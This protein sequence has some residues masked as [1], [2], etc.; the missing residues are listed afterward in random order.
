MH[1]PPH[2]RSHVHLECNCTGTIISACASKLKRTREEASVASATAEQLAASA[3]ENEEL[4][5]DNATKEQRIG[6][7]SSSLKE[8][9]E[10]SQKLQ[11]QLE[12]AGALREK[13][14]FS[15]ASSREADAPKET[16]GVS[17]T[18]EN[19]SKITASMTLADPSNALFAF[20]SGASGGSARFM[21]STSNHS[22]L[23]APSGDAGIAAGLRPM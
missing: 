22:L 10:N 19:A 3:K 20:V 23:G 17:V 16:G 6:E 21:P 12:A 5:A 13:F 9:Q 1:L 4:K 15:K 18:T 2:S 11:T 8:I 14:D 7:L